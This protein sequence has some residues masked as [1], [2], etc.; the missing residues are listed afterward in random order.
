MNNINPTEK[1][2]FPESSNNQERESPS[3]KAATVAEPVIG[4]P[5][6]SPPS[7]SGRVDQKK[8]GR[9]GNDL[10]TEKNPL[11]N[12]EKKSK[13]SERDDQKKL[14]DQGN[15]DAQFSYAQMALQG[16]GGEKDLVEARM[17]FKLAADQG[18]PKAQ[19]NYALMARDEKDLVKASKYFK[20]AADQGHLKAQYNYAQA[21]RDE[22]KTV[23]AKKYFKLAADQG[24]AQAQNDYAAMARR[25]KELVEAK[26]YF[27]LAAD[28]GLALAQYNYAL[29]AREENEPVEARNYFKLSADQG[30]SA[31][32]YH[33]ALMLQYGKG[34]GIDLDKAREYFK[35]AAEQNLVDARIHYQELKILK[36]K[37][38]TQDQAY[39]ISELSRKKSKLKEKNTKLKRK[40]SNFSA[41]VKMTSLQNVISSWCDND[42]ILSKFVCLIS[43]S[44][45]VV[46]VLGPDKNSLYEKGQIELWLKDNETS[47]V[48]R[49]YLTADMLQPMPKLGAL[50]AKRL[51]DLENLIH[52]PKMALKL[53]LKEI[54]EAHQEVKELCPGLLYL[55]KDFMSGPDTLEALDLH[56]APTKKAPTRPIFA[57]L[58]LASS[59]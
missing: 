46:P 4:G 26:K 12:T 49:S 17:Y 6:P 25:E 5:N 40:N 13:T 54:F 27:K 44:P 29:M 30:F 31:A 34:G 47:P 45:I 18:H 33:Y 50:I 22:K 51:K 21:A 39:R 8:R 36:L 23:E 42:P 55:F 16:V 58:D 56:Q 19:Y 3:K 57:Y 37:D 32:Q 38:K 59:N 14:A 41:Q 20:L 1:P 35:L 52:N 10:D 28:Q 2:Y 24:L 9:D 15:I 43:S 7:L 48:D 11:E 53:P